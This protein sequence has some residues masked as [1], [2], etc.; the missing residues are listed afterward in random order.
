MPLFIII[1]IVV[2]ISSMTTHLKLVWTMA[3]LALVAAQGEVYK[4]IENKLDPEA[5][6]LDGGSPMIYVHQGSRP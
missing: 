5:M 6:C 3:I 2:I 4:K 1:F